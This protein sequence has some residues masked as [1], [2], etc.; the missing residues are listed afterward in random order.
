VSRG[1][2]RWQR[3]ILRSVSDGQTHYLA[4]LLPVGYTSAEYN[5]LNRAAVQLEDA[6]RIAVYRF[7][8]GYHKTVVALPGVPCPEFDTRIGALN[9]GRRTRRPPS[10]VYAARAALAGDDARRQ[11]ELD[12]EMSGT[13][14]RFRRNF[15]AAL[16]RADDVWQFDID[17]IA[18][19]YAADFDRD[20]GPWLTEMEQWCQHV[21]DVVRRKSGLRAVQA[22]D[23]Q[24]D[25]TT[26]ERTDS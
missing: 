9:V 16:A 20:L 15:S 11:A 18:E 8:H 21:S 5:A 10:N 23:D 1:P 12:A 19:L 13:A 2:G 4:R 25:T 24:D 14:V 17:R 26:E 3:L 22:R 7:M 6:G